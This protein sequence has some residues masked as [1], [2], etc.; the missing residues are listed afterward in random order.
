MYLV[1]E[2]EN[3]QGLSTNVFLIHAANVEVKKD[4]NLAVVP[5]S[6]EAHEIM[7]KALGQEGKALAYPCRKW[8][9]QTLAPTW[10]SFVWDSLRRDVSDRW[11]AKDPEFT[12][13]SRGW[14]ILQ[15]KRLIALFRR[16]GIGMPRLTARPKLEGRSLVLKWDREIGKVEL[17]LKKVDSGRWFAWRNIQE[18]NWSLGTMYLNER[19]GKL[20]VTITYER[21]D[22]LADLDPE[23]AMT[24]RLPDA[25]SP[26][27]RLEGLR[28]PVVLSVAGASSVLDRLR[29][30]MVARERVKAAS[31][32]PVKQWGSKKLF[33]V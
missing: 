7:Q 25:T 19:E 2:V 16:R 3:S 29:I 30:Q 28:Q 8:V 27:I 20:R 31:G 10:Y 21:P 13:A 4:G 22:Q 14:L 6:S 33:R 15:G 24:V 18:G 12:K 26:D 11:R 23:L 1:P 5:H 17:K 32:S 9:L